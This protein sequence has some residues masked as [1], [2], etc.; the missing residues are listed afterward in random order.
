V[1]EKRC[2]NMEHIEELGEIKIK[3]RGGGN[4]IG[5]E[6]VAKKGKGGEINRI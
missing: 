6:K 2:K 4:A 3:G 5:T 1:K